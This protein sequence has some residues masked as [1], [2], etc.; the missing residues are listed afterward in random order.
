LSQGI[1][2]KSSGR[3]GVVLFW[4]RASLINLCGGGG[5]GKLSILLSSKGAEVTELRE[6]EFWIFGSGTARIE[7]M[8]VKG[9]GFVGVP[10]AFGPSS[11][12]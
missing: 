11:S 2:G 7:G 3:T 6:V 8:R 12:K 1:I 9:A 5:G 4:G 10:T